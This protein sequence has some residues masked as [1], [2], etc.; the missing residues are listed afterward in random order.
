M[1]IFGRSQLEF[2][3]AGVEEDADVTEEPS[4]NRRRG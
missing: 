1:N 2:L 4:V 3:P